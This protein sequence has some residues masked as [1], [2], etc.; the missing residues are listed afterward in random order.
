MVECLTSDDY[1]DDGL[2]VLYK[3]FQKGYAHV[4]GERFIA[5]LALSFDFVHEREFS[6][7]D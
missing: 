5:T 2:Y 4:F 7:V 1:F 6:Y 3:T